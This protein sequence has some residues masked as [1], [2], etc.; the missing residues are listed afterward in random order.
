MALG[1][2]SAGA[3]ALYV[4]PIGNDS[5]S[6][7]IAQPWRRVAPSLLKLRAGDTLSIR[8]GKYFETPVASVSGTA[9]APIV[10]RAYP[11]ETVVLDSGYP[12]FQTPGNGEWELVNAATGEYRSRGSYSGGTIYGYVDPGR[13]YEDGRVALVPYVSAAPFR[14]TS[15]QYD[16][17]AAHP[18]YVGPGTFADPDGRIHIRLAKTSDLRAAES[19]YGTVFASDLP[20]PRDYAIYL[21]RATRTLRVT[22][23]YWVFSGLT[24]DQAEKTIDLGAGVHDLRFENITAWNGDRAIEAAEAGTHH[25]TVTQ[26]RIYGDAPY[27]VFWSDMKDAPYPAD[28]L[29]GTSIDL[30]AGAHDWEI[31]WCHVRGC[32]QDLLG[33]ADAEYNLSIHHNRFENAGD[34]ALELEG[35]LGRAEV[36]ENFFINC[37]VAVAPGQSSP[38]F[39]G[40]LFIYRNVVSSLRNPAVNRKAGINTWN[41]GAKYGNEYAFKINSS[42]NSTRNTHLYHNTVVM[43]NSGGK[44]VNI[45]PRFPQGTRVANNLLV[46]VNGVVNGSMITGLDQ[47]VDGDL[48]WKVN[49]VDTKHLIGSY[50]TVAGLH[51]ATGLETHGLGS[52]PKR[53]T[54]PKFASWPLQVVDR[55]QSV[56]TITAAS[57]RTTP[58]TFLLASTSPARNAGIVIPPPPG[59][60]ALP[61]SR[62]S[63]DMGALPYGTSATEF[64][65]FPFNPS[66]GGTVDVPEPVADPTVDILVRVAPNPTAGRA[67]VSFTLSR[68]GPARLELLDVQGRRVRSL[69]DAWLSAGPHALDFDARGGDSPLQAGVYFYRLVAAGGE[70]RGHI[71]VSR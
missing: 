50:D 59:L 44:G 22:G 11:G 3:R 55:S 43:L 8:A 66:G 25:V 35:S 56:W 14:A 64:D 67:R 49:T 71:V 6:G 58:A 34:D 28:K 37:L 17:S 69:L 51:S 2:A 19:R 60:A 23:S 57:E 47:V 20:N 24:F 46:M 16:T 7:S 1:A 15:D 68:E 13:P 45:V 54:D 10:V 40:P 30:R 18:F 29:R 65:R 53:G 63:R 61:D 36:Y 26:S 38:G 27:W 42:D 39:V 52:T 31:S 12:E 4:S 9:A 21:S 5:N 70:A 33:T 32:G 62:A 41:G 48:Y